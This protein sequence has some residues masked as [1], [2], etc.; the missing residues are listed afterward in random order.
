MTRYNDQRAAGRGP[1]APLLTFREI[2]KQN[3]TKIIIT[4]KI[5]EWTKSTVMFKVDK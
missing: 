3:K 2:K 4:R 5:Y 1:T